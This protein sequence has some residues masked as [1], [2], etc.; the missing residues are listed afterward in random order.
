VGDPRDLQWGTSGGGHAP[1]AQLAPDGRAIRLSSAQDNWL[2]KGGLRKQRDHLAAHDL[3][4]FVGRN[5]P[6]GDHD[7]L[8]IEG[9]RHGG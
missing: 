9:Q 4:L 8:L 2:R 3:G 5:Q 7:A 1:T 6:V